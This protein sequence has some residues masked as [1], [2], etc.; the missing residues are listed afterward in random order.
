MLLLFFIGFQ[1]GKKYD[2][3]L[4]ENDEYVTISYSLNEQKMR[5]LM[6]LIDNYYVDSI[7][8]NSLVDK[9]IDFVTKNLDPHTTYIPQRLSALYDQ[10]LSGFYDGIGVGFLTFND[11]LVVT[12]TI[13][14]SPNKDLFKLGDRILSIQ[15]KKID[16][17]NLDSIRYYIKGKRKSSVLIEILRDG[18]TK[19]ILAKREN[20][21]RPTVSLYYM[22]TK[23]IGYIKLDHFAETSAGEFRNALSL[24]KKQGMTSLIFDLRNNPGGLVDV[25]QEIADEFLKE[26]QLIVYTQ[27]RRGTKR[28][29][30]ATEKGLFEDKPVYILIDGGTASASEIVAGAIQDHDA[31]TIIGRRSYGKGLVQKEISLGDGSKIRLTIAKYYT[32]TGRSIQKPYSISAEEYESD[33]KN[34]F[35]RGEFFSLD[36]IKRIDSLQFKT[37][38]GK[39]VYGGGGIIPDAFIPLDTVGIDRWYFEQGYADNLNIPIFK[40]IDKNHQSLSK[41]NEEDFIKF[42]NTTAFSKTIFS[43]LNVAEEEKKIKFEDLNFYIK[44]IIA[45]MLYGENAYNK[46]WNQRDPMILK[47]ESIDKKQSL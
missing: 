33:L 25:A 18:E 19:K 32:P 41:I 29:R 4:D 10:E 31:G 15:N 23:D 3:V 36:S 42:Y 11:T 40:F 8:T 47:A 26:D 5:R 20:I 1:V 16:S 17:T 39:I 38:K 7:D 43:Q 21:Q 44:A 12:N 34:R 27:D 14:N 30:Y 2:I 24:L 45:R 9:T 28:F 37:P 13:P 22:L 46:I 35:E 6:S